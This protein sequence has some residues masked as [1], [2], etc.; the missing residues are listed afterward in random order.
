[1]SRY[2]FEQGVATLVVVLGVTTPR[3]VNGPSPLPRRGR[4]DRTYLSVLCVLVL[5]CFL[6]LIGARFST[7]GCNPLFLCWGVTS[8][9]PVNGPSPLPRRGGPDRTYLSV[10][11]VL[12]LKCFLL[13]IG[14]R[15][16]T[17]GCNTLFLCWGWFGEFLQ[18]MFLPPQSHLRCD[19]P[20]LKRGGELFLCGVSIYYKCKE[21]HCCGS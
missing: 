21:P 10:L 9:R 11:C 3:P 16:S 7:R 8:P 4:P 12:V 13:L 19:F 15:F 18:K 14:A 1:M 5:K 20:L 6:L 2:E 17:R